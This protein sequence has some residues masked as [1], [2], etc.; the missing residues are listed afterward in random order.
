MKTT[1]KVTAEIGGFDG[2]AKGEEYEADYDPER[3]RWGIEQGLIEK[4]GK[5]TK[6]KEGSTDA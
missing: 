4:V 5:S 6:K 3:E 2:H 1:Y